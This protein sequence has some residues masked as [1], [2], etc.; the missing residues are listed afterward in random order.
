MAVNRREDRHC[1]RGTTHARPPTPFRQ[2]TTTTA[3]PADR[4]HQGWRLS[5]GGEDEARAR[6]GGRGRWESRPS[7]AGEPAPPGEPGGRRPHCRWCL[8]HLA[9]YIKRPP[10]LGSH[11]PRFFPSKS[12]GLQPQRSGA[13]RHCPP[14]ARRRLHAAA[15]L[16]W[17]RSRC[18]RPR[19]ACRR[20]SALAADA[21]ADA[22]AAAARATG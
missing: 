10:R 4:G 20:C 7:P 19:S 22:A 5:P 2:T 18:R 17:R 3:G 8:Y 1:S 12:R 9:R 6:A 13:G 11:S 16:S 14:L 15:L 21:A